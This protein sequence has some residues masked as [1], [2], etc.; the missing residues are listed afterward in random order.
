M[1]MDLSGAGG[2]FR[3]SNSGWADILELGQAHGW[4]PVGTGPPRRELKSAWGDGPYFGNGGQRFYAR[5]AQSLADALVSPLRSP[6][7]NWSRVSSEPLAHLGIGP[8]PLERVGVPLVVFRPRRLGM[9]QEF[10]SVSP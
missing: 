2:Y 8:R 1:G 5:D 4:V 10:L 9:R 6:A 3:W 7:R